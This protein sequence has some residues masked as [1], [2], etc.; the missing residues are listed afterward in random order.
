[1]DFNEGDR[2]VYSGPLAPRDGV[3][4]VVVAV[5]GAG[6]FH[7]AVE[8]VGT[9]LAVAPELSPVHVAPM[10]EVAE[11]DAASA[12]QAEQ[13]PAEAPARPAGDAEPASGQV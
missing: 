9:V 6:S 8:G 10:A 2:V 1:M 11:S 4:G 12:S 13:V 5:Q 7:V 3:P